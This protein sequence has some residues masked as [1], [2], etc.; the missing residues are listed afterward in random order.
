[1]HRLSQSPSELKSH[2]DVIVVGSG[3]GGG[4]AASRLSRAGK[5]VC[6]L[7]RGKEF[8]PG[9]FP[10]NPLEAG[11]EI[12]LNTSA[13]HIG[14]A[15]GLY[16]FHM[17]KDINVLVG[18][19]LGGTS[20][21]NANVVIKPD[22]RVFENSAW[23]KDLIDDLDQGLEEGYQHSTEMLKANPYPDDQPRLKKMEALGKSAKFINSKFAN[24]FHQPPIAV[25]FND[26]ASGKNHVGLDQTPCILCGD[27]VSGCNHTSKNTVQM[28]YLADAWNHGAEIFTEVNVRYFERN[29]DRWVVHFQPLETGREKFD[30]PPQSITADVVV[31]A[32]GTLGSNEILLRSGE[33]GL[34]LSDELGKYF[35]G[36][37]DVLAF[38]YN[39]DQSINGVGWGSKAPDPENPVGPC[40]SSIIDTREDAVDYKEGMSIEEGSI[41]GPLALMLPMTFSVL[42]KGIG[43]DTDFGI[44]DALSEFKRELESLSRGSCYGAINHTQT[45]LVM[46]HDDA[47]GVIQLED[48]RPRISW[49]G[50][51]KQKIFQKVKDAL[52]QTAKALGGTYIPNPTWNKF[53]DHNLVT[54]HPLG[55]CNMA[56]DAS[57]GVVNH[58]CQVFSSNAGTE[59]HPGLYVT[60]GAVIPTSVGTNP[61]STICAIAER[62]VK[63]MAEDF[64]WTF[65]Y[66]LPSKPQ[67]NIPKRA[68][69]IQFTE[70]MKGFFSTHHEDGFEKAAEQG[71]SEDSRFEFVL[72]V[73]SD[74]LDD[75]LA[76]EDHQGQMFGT[77][78]APSIFS[79]PLTVTQGIFNLFVKDPEN[80][81]VRKMGY[82]FTMHAK[83]G[84]KW[85]VDGFKTIRNDAG[86]DVIKDTTTL[87]ITVHEG[88]DE[89]APIFGKGVLHIEPLDF[90]K[91]MTTMK[92]THVDSLEKRLE[93]IG[94]FG[95]FFTG[96]LL[97]IYG[98]VFA[99]NNYFNP[100][101]PARKKRPLRAPE[102]EVYPF[103][104]EDN[105]SLLLTR[106]KGGSKGPVILSHGLGV[107]SRIFSMDTLNTNLLEF[108]VAH[109]YDVWLLDYRASIELPEAES[110]F[111]GDD[112]AQFDYPA[113]ISKVLEVTKASS[114]QMV[115]HCFGATT[116]TLSMLGGW[117]K[118]VRS[119]VV[120]QVSAHMKVPLLT[121]LKTGLH[122]PSLLEKIGVDSLTAFVTNDSE[123]E[124]K[125]FDQALRF[126]PIDK[127]ELCD[128]PVCRRITFLYGQLYEHD[129]LNTATHD[130]L[131]EM[132]GVANIQSLEHLAIMG[133]K[134]HAVS[135]KGD[136]DYLPHLNRMNIPITFISGDENQCFLPESSKLTYKALRKENGKHLYQRH[137][138]PNYGHIDCIFGKNASKDVYPIILEHLEA[139]N[140]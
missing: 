23:P 53:F 74:D 31:L 71:R 50:V 86:F 88:A 127:E 40:I 24:K 129:Q 78:T 2:Y 82:R 38:Q 77:V 51:G 121:G 32:A 49:P 79:E 120:S 14:K 15:T 109:H 66:Q 64:Q 98:G 105:A 1:M 112:I 41:P 4:I 68:P 29:N 102:P 114:V 6:V 17:N 42:S 72:T 57:Q 12:Q 110:K 81:N 124:K 126:Y 131:H 135:L 16:N 22:P 30:A 60:D 9:E 133:R 87:Y 69:G 21:I 35:T 20:L 26:H 10:D 137:V 63:L 118:N 111:S 130:H 123:L 75:M 128:N 58:K 93:Y 108:L 91:Q 37:G 136:E 90:Q 54:V 97:D 117:L 104:T 139:T 84:K 92:A 115:V 119:A 39:N 106:Y 43:K 13:K 101:A 27:C 67:R 62:A 19:G 5:Q 61:L 70:S 25:N 85:Y 83:D 45:L 18:C 100:D 48:D 116:W 80:V 73:T 65:D 11:Q 59:V 33:N 89:S 94:K 8:L 7:E 34:T 36:N 96:A 113:A 125:L 46:T 140:P 107:S 56:E 52:V 134:G 132:F 3:Y 95:K 103:K 55:G 44:P 138:I 28:T 76:N 122:V 99:R 47:N